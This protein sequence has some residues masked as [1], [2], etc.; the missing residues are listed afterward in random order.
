MSKT[1]SLPASII[2]KEVRLNHSDK[3][4]TQVQ[5]YLIVEDIFSMV[6]PEVGKLASSKPWLATLTTTSA[7]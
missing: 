6:P 1:F 5:V 3:N 2:M 4:P 7:F